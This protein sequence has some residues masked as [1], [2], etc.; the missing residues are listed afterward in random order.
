MLNCASTPAGACLFNLTD[1]PNEHNDV[2][3]A[4]PDIVA[5]MKTALEAAIKDTFNP[6]RGSPDPKAC[7]AWVAN[8]GWY[9]P[10]VD[11]NGGGGARD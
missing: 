7:E 1:D 4:H 2:A 9:G 11:V 8:D 5:E 6:D 3:D 10:W